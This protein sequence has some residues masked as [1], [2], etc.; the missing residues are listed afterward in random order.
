MTE[1]V[2]EIIESL[3]PFGGVAF[4]LLYVVLTVLFVPGT[5]PSVAAGALFGPISGPSWP[6]GGCTTKGCWP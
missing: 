1:Q 3:G 6:T 4:V 2:R 5:I